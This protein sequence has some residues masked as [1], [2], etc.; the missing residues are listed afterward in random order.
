MNT[1]DDLRTALAREA[2]AAPS[3]HHTDR[4]SAVRGRVAV[5]RRR[6]RAAAA[7]VAV[8]AIGTAGVVATMPDSE[9]T[10]V[11][12]QVFG[13]DVPE[14]MT[15]L[16][17]TYELDDTVVEG[18]AQSVE[19]ELPASDEP[20]LVSWATR[21]DDHVTVE[22]SPG[23]EPYA[24][25]APDFADFVLL[26]PGES[27]TV[28]IRGAEAGIALAT[29]TLDLNDLPE[30]VGEGL[31]R[32]RTSVVD[33]DFLIARQGEVGQASVS[34]SLVGPADP[35]RS[36]SVRV[37]C[38]GA[39]AGSTVNV[40]VEGDVGSLQFGR[41]RGPEFDPAGN[42]DA[43]FDP[44]EFAGRDITLR[45]WLTDRDGQEVTQAPGVR[46]GLGAY[47]EDAPGLSAFGHDFPRLMESD[48]HVWEMVDHVN[49][50]RGGAVLT[51]PSTGGAYLVTAGADGPGEMRLD[52]D[53]DP[54][55]G[56]FRFEM[57]GSIG[58]LLVPAETREVR[59]T[60]SGL[61]RRSSVP[62]VTLVLYELVR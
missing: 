9:R 40:G 49:D 12:A 25:Q 42:V 27:T 32:F 2:E 61:G 29:Y 30:G 60:A 16:G 57:A 13:I 47:H 34:V 26:H 52:A 55:G 53:G 31:S 50:L 18:D 51:L 14:T 1:L 6:Q 36:L 22:R 20:R 33:R 10:P 44:R 46:L 41:C 7:F 37:T 43:T 3:G 17:W 5:H 45:A 8:A 59:L 15:S 56:D 24:S 21:G 62:A 35:D 48:G 58:H 11:A 39:P 38:E 4:V 23:Y 28:S 19:V 54:F